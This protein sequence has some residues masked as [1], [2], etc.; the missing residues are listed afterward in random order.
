M[1]KLRLCLDALEVD[2]FRTSSI[3]GAPGTVRGH[4]TVFT[5]DCSR[6]TCPTFKPGCPTAAE[7]CPASCADGC[8]DV[9]C[10]TDPGLC[11]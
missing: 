7:T 4:D 8:T 6:F 3:V 11:A 10:V 1:K 5:E 2:S 9:D